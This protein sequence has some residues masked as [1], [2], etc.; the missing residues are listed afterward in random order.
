[1]SI[2]MIVGVLTPFLGTVLGSALVFL[3]R[4]DIP[5]IVEKALLG[6][7]GGV[8]MSASFFSLILPAMEQIESEGKTSWLITSVG[9][10]LGIAFL[11]VLDMVVPHMHVNSDEEEGIHTSWKKST[12]L[13]FAMTLHN[14]P[15]GMALGI[16]FASVLDGNVVMSL[17]GAIAFSIGIAIQ[18]IPEGAVISMPLHQAGMNKFKAFIFGSGSGIVEPIG[19]MVTIFFST[20]I[21]PFLPWLLAFAAGAMVYVVIEELVPQSQH[22]RHSN[23]GTIMFALGFVCMMIL[24]SALA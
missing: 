6:F 3:L 13:F 4:K 20:L 15:E 24:D 5:E 11:L 9:F 7:A 21:K 19:A 8:M 12:K 22:G 2:N 16:V 1:M 10:L 23:I 14:V 17:S 18:N